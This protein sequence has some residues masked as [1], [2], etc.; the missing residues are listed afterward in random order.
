MTPRKTVVALT[1]FV[2]VHTPVSDVPGCRH[3][4][5]GHG[6]GGLRRVSDPGRDGHPRR[7]G[8]LRPR[9]PGRAGPRGSGGP[10]DL[11]HGATGVTGDRTACVV[12]RL[13]WVEV[14]VAY[15]TD[16]RLRTGRS[17]TRGG[18][19]PLGWLISDDD[20]GERLSSVSWLFWRKSRGRSR[21]ITKARLWRTVA[22]KFVGVFGADSKS[23]VSSTASAPPR[24]VERKGETD[25][26]GETEE[27]GE[28]EILIVCERE[29]TFLA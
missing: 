10:G 27:I 15:D 29:V 4:R 7:S 5:L 20:D 25:R 23:V 11:W 18:L 17:V 28:R 2:V 16:R 3:H 19:D 12:A 24:R 26:E 9:R 8:S 14:R 13:G 22:E 6:P 1:L 21:W